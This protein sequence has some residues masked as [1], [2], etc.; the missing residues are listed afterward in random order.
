MPI[1]IDDRINLILKTQFGKL[2][3]SS[4]LTLG[5][6]LESQFTIERNQIFGQPIPD[7]FP[8]DII[9]SDR[10]NFNQI[11][12]YGSKERILTGPN[13]LTQTYHATTN[14]TLLY[15][16][17]FNTITD[18]SNT[19]LEY[20]IYSGRSIKDI[21][22]SNNFI[23]YSGNYFDFETNNN[24]ILKYIIYNSDHQYNRNAP[25]DLIVYGKNS[26]NARWNYLKQFTLTHQDYLY[27]SRDVNANDVIL[28][29][30]FNETYYK[31]YRISVGRILNDF[32]EEAVR[33]IGGN[34]YGL[35]KQ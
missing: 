11:I 3:T 8:S 9:W 4:Q 12:E 6:E 32:N 17:A 34:I 22:Y 16:L 15:K 19:G 13:Y 30:S 5:Q 1:S 25:S 33:I 29:L 21:T 20:S 14:I 7:V 28:D 31:N 2:Y 18:F 35:T 24:T 10:E 26:N 27:D 23:D